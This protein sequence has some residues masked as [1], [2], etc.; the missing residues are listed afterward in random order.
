MAVPATSRERL[1]RRD[2]DSLSNQANRTI[3]SRGPHVATAR[4]VSRATE[5]RGFTLIE[6]LVATTVLVVGV[7]ALASLAGVATRANIAAR[8]STFTAVLAAAKMEQLR[9]LAWGFDALGAPISDSTTDLTVF[10]AT[11]GAGVGLGPSPPDALAHNTEGYCDFL[12]ANGRSLGGGPVPPPQAL[13]IRRWS[14]DPRPSD[15]ANTLVLQVLVMRNRRAAGGIARMLP[16]EAA[17][18]TVRTRKAT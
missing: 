13:F 12:D 11:S 1:S 17:V 14:I 15:P 10:P 9:A 2:A 4:G 3:A 18:V 16:D 7:V 6:V 5:P 8:T